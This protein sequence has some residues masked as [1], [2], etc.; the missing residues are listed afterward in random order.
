MGQRFIACDRE[1]SFLM[2]PDV[3]EWLPARHLAWFVIDA[4]EEMAL[5]GFYAAYRVD[6]RCRP[7]YD[8]AMMVA[9]LVYAYARGIRSSRMIERAC[10]EDV[11]FR[12]LAAQQRPDHATLARFVERHEDAIAGLFGEVLTLCA[13][14]GRV[15]VGV[16]AV[17][18]TKLQANASRNENLDYEQLAREIVEEA[19][20][21]DAAEDELYGTARG[22]ELP[23]EFATAQGRRGWLREAKQRLEAERAA[24]PQPVPRSR[25]KRVKEAK[26]RLDEELWTEVRANRAYEAYRARGRMKNGRRFGRPP[27]PYQPPAAAGGR[28]NLTGPDSRVVKGLRGFLQGYNAQAVTN[29][30]QVVFGCRDRDRRRGLR[31]PRADARRRT[32]RAH[33]R[34]RRRGARGVAGRR[35]LLARR[36]DATD[37]QP[38]HRGHHPARHQPPPNHAA[39]LG[40]RPLP[41]DA[42][43]ASHRPRQRA[44]PQAPTDDRT[45]VCPDEV[46]PRPG[47]L[48][49]TRTRRRPHGMATDHRHPQPPQTPPT[50]PRHRRTPP[51]GRQPAPPAESNPYRLLADPEPRRTYATAKRGKTTRTASAR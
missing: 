1:Q 44:L 2:P 51:A 45:R 41:A 49:T 42:R 31:A 40:R 12:V 36:A 34:R 32:P 3:R 8:P 21:V 24:R 6:G 14:S 23:P 39:Q 4:V 22:D 33:G 27:D 7:A 15:Q 28:I 38:R 47:P 18:G 35:G 5:D 20:A 25:P 30:H 50:R 37:H 46:Q 10:E 29:E 43:R 13:R 48:P 19:Q 11:A 9:V 26:R 16:I 17:D